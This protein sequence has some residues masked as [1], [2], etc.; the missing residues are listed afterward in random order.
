MMEKY[1]TFEI[2]EN[3]ETNEIYH[4]KIN[5]EIGMEKIADGLWK[6]RLD[7]EELET[8]KPTE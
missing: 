8:E 2:W 7:L 3:T 6:R 1:G 4:K 5:D